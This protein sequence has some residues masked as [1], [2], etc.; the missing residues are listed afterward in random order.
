MSGVEIKNRETHIGAA[1]HNKKLI[2]IW[3]VSVACTI[4]GVVTTP[5]LSIVP[6]VLFIVSLL[7]FNSEDSLV[8][9]FG[10]LPFANIF[11]LSTTST[12]LFTVCELALVII[13]LRRYKISASH[14][15]AIVLL[16]VYMIAFSINN[17]DLL[18]VIKIIF[19]FLIISVAKLT[20]SKNGLKKIARLLSLGT[21]VMLLLSMN[22]TYYLKVSEYF[23]DLNYVEPSVAENSSIIRISGFLGDPNYCTTL[24]IITI[25]LLCVLYYYK[26]IGNLEF[27][28]QTVVLGSLGFFTY[29]KS[30]FL[31]ILLLLIFFILFVLFPKYKML[32]VL[33]LGVIALMG[34]LIFNGKIEVFNLIIG[35]FETGDLTTGRADLN[36][37]YLNYIFNNIKVLVFGDGI[38]TSK[39]IGMRKTVHCIYIEILYKLGIVGTLLYLVTLITSLSGGKKRIKRHFVNYLPL[40][41]FLLVFAFLAGVAFYA[42]PFYIII[43]FAAMNY[44]NVE[45]QI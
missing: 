9:L 21:I 7:S 23:F 24:I 13:F 18:T 26:S 14:F 3:I 30:F 34:Y 43:S 39:F 32:S 44:T 6:F 5:Y 33:M 41:F 35:R 28:S 20:I 40:F 29:S 36:K 16:S 1:I 12:S 45:K 15:I 10:L 2:I 31:S 17:F 8:L 22:Q 19:G 38:S 4:I 37:T 25:S 27:W 42:L 11:K